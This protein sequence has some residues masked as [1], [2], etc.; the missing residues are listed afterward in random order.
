MI[1]RNAVIS[2][3]VLLLVTNAQ[4]ARA[5]N[6]SP[7]DK[8]PEIWFNPRQESVNPSHPGMVF[9]KFD[10]PRMLA[11]DAEWKTA[12]SHLSTLGLHIIHIIEG[13]PD[14]PSVI[15]WINRHPFRIVGDGSVV[16]TGTAIAGGGPAC[17]H[18][19][20]EG[21]D[22]NPRF[23]FAP[24]VYFT[25]HKWKQMG[26]R[27][28]YLS[29]DTPF[30]FAY[31]ALGKYCHYSIQQVA[32]RTAVTVNKVLEDFPNA[33]IVDAEGPGT[34]PEPQ[35]LADY[36]QFIDSF[37]AASHRPIT[38]ISMDMHW[39]DAWHTGY[40]WIDATRTF[41][42]FA[43]A[44]HIKAGLLMDAEDRYMESGDGRSISTTP[45]TEAGWMQMVRE[46]MTLTKAD[47]LPVDY[48]QIVSW[49][50]FPNHNLPET[51]P[52]TSTS[53]VNDAYRIWH[54]N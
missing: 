16:N 29:L 11:S 36:K 6:S 28:D 18:P 34:I 42:S 45:V 24:E 35:F 49:M 52:L 8:M 40:N 5:A 53:L 17:T 2:T 26:G 38:H 15:A 31:Y 30:G 25:L 9:S 50:K 51:D 4:M 44:N 32:Q 47:N 13:Y 22:S 7:P 21:V 1:I 10:F 19:P 12:Q 3:V 23:D 46:H 54:G 14:A 41:I 43:H 33:Q 27:L 39:I 20:I 37:N 48:I